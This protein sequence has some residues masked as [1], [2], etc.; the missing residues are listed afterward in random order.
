MPALALS[1]SHLSPIAIFL[2]SHVSVM[3]WGKG[4]EAVVSN[5]YQ[6]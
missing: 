4:G 5:H 2:I 6:L 3:E 1:A